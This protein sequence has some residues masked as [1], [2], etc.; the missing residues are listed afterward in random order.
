MFF[1]RTCFLNGKIVLGRPV[2]AGSGAGLNPA[3]FLGIIRGNVSINFAWLW[4]AAAAG[5]EGLH[6]RE[7][8]AGTLFG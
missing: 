8:T 4:H 2:M 5:Q 3:G 7:K 1:K 6:G